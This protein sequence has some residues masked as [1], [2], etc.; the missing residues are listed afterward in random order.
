MAQDLDDEEIKTS[1]KGKISGKLVYAKN[2]AVAFASIGLFRSKDSTSAGGTLSD[3]KGFFEINSIS[4][5]SY[6]IVIQGINFQKFKSKKFKI[7]TETPEIKF[8]NINLKESS[9]Q[10]KE[11]KITEQKDEI[12]YE[13]DKKIYTLGANLTTAGGT[14]LDVLQNV[15]SVVVDNN[16]DVALRGSENI[17]ILVD[18]RPS[19]LVVNNKQAALE[20][21]PASMIEAIEVI[22]NPSAK[23]TAEATSGIL[24]IITKKNNVAGYNALVTA[25]L[26]LRNRENGSFLL[27]IRKNKLN[28]YVDYDA[29]DVHKTTYDALNRLSN[30]RKGQSQID[31]QNDGFNR[32]NNQNMKGGLD[33]Y[34]SKNQTISASVLRRNALEKN[35]DQRF[36]TSDYLREG[37]ASRLYIRNGQKWGTQMGMDYTL[38][39]QIKLPKPQQEL[40]IDAVYLT[41]DGQ[42][43]NDFVQA[44]FAGNFTKPSQTE[45]TRYEASRANGQ[46]NQLT[47]Q[48]DYVH[49]LGPKNRIE[50]GLRANIRHLSDDF[51]YLVLDKFLDIYFSD[52]TRS[53][54][55]VYDEN[56]QAGYVS[57]AFKEKKWSLLAGLRGEYTQINISQKQNTQDLKQDYFN[58]F[59]SVFFNKE[60]NDQQRWQFSYSKRINRPSYKSLNP[61]VNYAD[62]LNLK[63]G[64]PNLKPE[65]VNS[66]EISHLY[67]KKKFSLNPSLFY[68]NIQNAV[69]RVRSLTGIDTTI[70][71]YQNLGRNDSYGLEILISQKVK[72]SWKFNANFSAFKTDIIGQTTAGDFNKSNLAWMTR[73]NGNVKFGN[74][75]LLQASG[76]Y[77]STMLTAQ[78]TVSAVKSLDIGLKKSILNNQGSINIRINDVFNTLAYQ[79]KTEGTGFSSG[80]YSK[81]ESR[82]IFVGISY[83]FAKIIETTKQR[84]RN[85]Q[86]EERVKEDDWEE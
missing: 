75:F 18:G 40:T 8:G 33:W 49:P 15:P 68:R 59:P 32:D 66:L 82:F 28:I 35:D 63:S 53:N 58:V 23:Y 62:P 19:G 24:N 31:Q 71:T 54:R 16:G 70:L 14:L 13:L 42:D 69:T 25:N 21:L 20:M 5:G 29:R 9:K 86:N 30:T 80:T 50:I 10:L 72:K 67:Q 56:V 2:Q 44:Y 36:S 60:I 45:P 85:K 34:L 1:Q 61:F 77:R 22:T 57:Y 73:L 55:F 78:G 17:L 4:F 52:D 41:N 74:G 12:K 64:N 27:N 11:I 84:E 65:L 38:G 46:N 37:S 43:N 39:Y 26:G 81:K 83:R 76:N 79:I 6:Y 7:N 3:E 48:T 47:I 51:Q